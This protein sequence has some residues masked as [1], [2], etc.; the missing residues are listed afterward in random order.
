IP[1][2]NGTNNLVVYYF[3]S[4]V[5]EEVVADILVESGAIRED[6]RVA[7]LTNT[8]PCYVT[9]TEKTI[10]RVWFNKGTTCLE[11]LRLIAE[12][13]QYRFYFDQDGN[14]I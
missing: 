3:K 6:Q 4:Q 1:Y 14:P 11:A 9:P 10:D 8:E 13:V 2:Y 7:W 5:P 12:A